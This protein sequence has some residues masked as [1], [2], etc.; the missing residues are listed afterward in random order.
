MPTVKA[1]LRPP[2]NKDG[3]KPIYIR[4]ADADKT[5]YVSTGLKVKPA[6]WNDNKREVRENDF[7]DAAHLNKIISDRVK[8]IRDESYHLKADKQNVNADIL[9]KKAK[10]KEYRGSFI[11]YGKTFA[12][13]KRR[14]NVRT[15]KR[16]DAVI[17]KIEEYTGGKLQFK[18]VTV[19]WLKEFSAW[20]A[21]EKDNSPNTIHSNLKCI[22]AI[23]YEAI[24]E[25]QFPQEK[26]PFFKFKLKQP[27]VS[28]VK[29]SADEI[30]ALANVE[31]NDNPVQQIALDMF[32]FSFFT[33]GM[34]Y[35]DVSQLKWKN[36][37]GDFIRYEM[38][39]TSEAHSVKIFPPARAILDKYKDNP[40]PDDY[41]FPLLNTKRN[42]DNRETLVNELGSKNAYVNK[43]LNN[44]RK[45]AEISKRVSFH[46][47]RHS[48]ADIARKKGTDLHAISNSLGHA[49]LKTT[50]SYLKALDN[51]TTDKKVQSVY[52]EF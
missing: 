32:L 13:Q 14:V 34:R 8:E 23:L 7:F 50:E 36:I 19:T 39:K 22:R 28:R 4:I 33:Y 16:Y 42:L 20:L 3:E 46:T 48:Y 24:R 43:E 51:E 11:E 30:K 29:L 37:E 10:S 31:T 41:V 15:G 9:K 1:V 5:R 12:Q 35:S 47:A 2:K 44:L 45:K 17:S 25:S 18:D 52:E 27:K 26:N 6:L 49:S 21:D 38:R 40:A